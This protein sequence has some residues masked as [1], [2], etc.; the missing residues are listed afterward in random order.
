MTSSVVTPNL[1]RK[2]GVSQGRAEAT[3]M[4]PVIVPADRYENDDERK[5]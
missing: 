5:G 3:P 4:E 2:S 1:S